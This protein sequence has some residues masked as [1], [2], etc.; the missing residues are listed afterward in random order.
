MTPKKQLP[1]HLIEIGGKKCCSA[2]KRPFETNS[3]PS[4]IAAFKA[5]VLSERKPMSCRSAELNRHQV[6]DLG[7]GQK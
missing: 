4:L 6:P 2:C 1:P 5:H 3:Q 7:L